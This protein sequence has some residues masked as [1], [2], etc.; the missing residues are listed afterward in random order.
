MNRKSLASVLAV[1]MMMTMLPVHSF[2]DDSSATEISSADSIVEI[3]DTAETDV[4]AEPETTAEHGVVKVGNADDL[5]QAVAA[6]KNNVE[7]TIRLTN[8]IEKMTTDQ[9]ITIAEGKNIVLDMNEHSIKVDANFAGRPIKNQGVLTVTGNGTI[10][11]SVS[12]TG[13]YGAIDNYGVLTIENGTYTG[14]VNASGASIKNRPDCTLTIK[15]GTFNGA[16]TAVYNE[17]ITTIYDGYFDC[18]SCSSCNPNS[19]GYTIQSHKNVNGNSPELYFYNGTVIGVQGAFS[20]SAGYTEIHDG[21]FETVACTKHTNGN[22]AYYAL[23]I[24]GEDEDV[25]CVVYDGTFKS[26]SK[27][28][29]LIGNDNTNGDGGINANAT[30]EIKGGTFIAPTNQKAITGATNTG[31]P[32]ITGGTFSS[33]VSDYVDASSNMEKD[34]TTGNWVAAPIP[35][36]DGVAEIDGKYYTSLSAAFNSAK[37][38]DTVKLLKDYTSEDRLVI[39]NERAITLDLNGKTLTSTAVQRFVTLNHVDAKLTIEDSSEN[40]GGMIVSPTGDYIFCIDKGEL[41]I[42]DGTVFSQ[43]YWPYGGYKYGNSIVWLKGSTDPDAENYAKFTLG[44][45]AKLVCADQTADDEPIGDGYAVMIDYNGTASYGTVVDIWGQTEHAGLYVQGMIT[46]TK[47]NVPVWNLHDGAYIDGGIY[48]AGYARW[49]ID[50]A[51]IIGDTGMEIRAGELTVEDGSVITGTA[52]PT[53]VDPNGNGSTT[54]GAGLAVAQHTTKL[55][56]LVT[57]NG[58]TISGFSAL[59]ESNPQE[60]DEDSILKVV[61][62]VNGGTFQAINGGTLPVYSEDKADFISGGHFSAPIDEQYLDD[63]LNAKLK[64][65]SNPEAPYSYYTSMDDAIAAAKPGDEVTPI[66]TDPAI[67]TYTVTLDYNDNSTGDVTCTVKENTAI[68]LPRPTRSGYT[69][70]GWYAG[71]NKV[72]SPYLV[73]GDATLVARWSKDYVPP[74]D[75]GDTAPSGDYIVFVETDGNGR[76]ILS[77]SRADKGDTVTITVKPD[78]GYD[79]DE[80]T[81]T[82]NKGKTIKLTSK[83]DNQYTF[84]MPGSEVTVEASFVFNSEPVSELPFYDVNEND[85][86]Y[87]AVVYAYENELM[88]GTSANTFA[89]NSQMTR[90]M[91][92]T[93]LAAYEGE[94][95]SGGATWYE[96]GQKWAMDNGISDGTNPNGAITREQ[97]AVMLWRY[98]GSPKAEMSLASYTDASAVSSWAVEAMAWAIDNG[99]ISG[100][101]NGILAPQGNATRAQVATIMMQF[102]EKF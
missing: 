78:A 9:I 52:T 1:A 45:D 80:L 11:S 12:N 17:G 22:S 21:S 94:N 20:S 48:A 89:P 68:S 5:T 28:A 76:V 66:Q 32:I 49:N 81:V 75:G 99:L 14:S 24:A 87:D 69:F 92:W 96:A 50:G 37:N 43:G 33:D 85:W 3:V 88:S 64:S 7:T 90:A 51:T 70:Q 39:N 73:T 84:E 35:E 60:N 79:L 40:D 71:S 26:V 16:P 63:S 93:V 15:N 47:G 77:P 97:L 8:D 91:I 23:Y 25:K 31:N 61:L 4:T 101:G 38:G 95:T 55:P 56:I 41:N 65:A 34:E 98:A 6:A 100:M 18:R 67:K 13:G 62:E 83:G 59:Y 102:V 44:K 82:D 42:Q 58:G 29:A 72:S 53:E 2:A 74:V 30:S 54:L 19:W 57:I 86:F 27:T 46:E 36:S 10:D